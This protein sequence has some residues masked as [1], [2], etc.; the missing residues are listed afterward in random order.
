MQWMLQTE[1]EE[2]KPVFEA[3]K[4]GDIAK[5][6]QFIAQDTGSTQIKTAVN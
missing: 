2:L 4:N 5:V 6:K 3:C 1:Q